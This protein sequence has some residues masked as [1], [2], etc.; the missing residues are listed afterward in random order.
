MGVRQVPENLGRL[1]KKARNAYKSGDRGLAAHLI[2]KILRQDYKNRRAWKLLYKQYGS[3]QP[4]KA[5][6][7]EFTEQYY[8]DKIDIITGESSGKQITPVASGFWLSRVARARKHPPEPGKTLPPDIQE[9]GKTT[10]QPSYAGDIPT[11]P[12]EQKMVIGGIALTSREISSP[13]QK[14]AH[15]PEMLAP[16]RIE[17]QIEEIKSP[18]LTA[19]LADKSVKIRVLVVDDNPQTR[20]TILRSLSF[21]TEIEVIATAENGIQAIELS[22]QTKPDVVLMDVNMPDMDGITATAGVLNEVPYAQVI[23]LTVQNDADYI[24]QAMMAGAHD[25]LSKPPGLDD[26]LNAV[27]QAGKVA[28]Q[29]KWKASQMQFKSS[30]YTP[31]P[32]SRGKIITIYSPKGG[33]GCTT[34]A[35]NLAVTLHNE[36]TRVVLVDGNFDFGDV[37]DFFNLQ[38]SF[39][40]FDLAMRVGDLDYQIVEDILVTHESGI[41]LLASPGPE[42]SEYIH[43][44]AYVEVLQFLRDLYP[45]ILVNTTSL[46]TDSVI[47]A[48]EIAD[49]VILPVIQDIP[50]VM[51]VRKF[52][53]TLQL[54]KVN[55]QRILVVLNQY[56]KNAE[57]SAEIISK[58]IKHEFDVWIPKDLR[59]V[60]PS[61]NR[62]VPFMLKDNL[63]TRP[64]SK[65][66]LDLAEIT[67]QRLL[68]LAQGN[69]ETLSETEKPKQR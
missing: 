34:I 18:P 26:L 15:T 12:I 55:P 46:L 28:H 35:A 39:S 9:S 43:T 19:T 67:R 4:M 64:V 8:P 40:L 16:I 61:V 56:E 23:I 20:D 33:V 17:P 29:E 48:L 7:I 57:L 54:L 53:D 31:S 47:A 42:Q 41:H 60:L 49:I 30:G 11:R 32:S 62:G 50:T 63:K 37:T 1:L 22:K 27:Q 36:E 66:F 58:T 68:L 21:Q 14:P 13:E 44:E 25:F 65:A 69:P 24:R 45:Y 2:D 59:V 3:G 51:R 10:D 38:S 5:F 52:I 6:Q